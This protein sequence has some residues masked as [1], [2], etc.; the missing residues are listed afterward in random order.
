MGRHNHLSYKVQILYDIGLTNSLLVRR[1]IEDAVQNINDKRQKE[2]IIDK[3]AKQMWESYY[4][5]DR[6]YCQKGNYK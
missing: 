2:F 1:T 6:T 3:I 5:G 4:D